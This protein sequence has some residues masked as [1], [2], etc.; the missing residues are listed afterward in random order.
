MADT[1][2]VEINLFGTADFSKLTSE[3]TALKAQISAVQKAASSVSNVSI[4]MQGVA[5]AEKNFLA[6][7][8]SIKGM[9]TEMV[10]LADGA[11]H[12]NDRLLKNNRTFG[13]MF[14]TWRTGSKKMSE[15]MRMIGQY[16]AKL[17]ESMVIP[18][19]ALN[20]QAMVL[21]NLAGMASKTK[22]AQQELKA[23]NTEMRNLGNTIVNTGKNMQWAGR[24]L[25]VGITV[26]MVAGGAA[27]ASMFL[28]VD[29]A[30]RKLMM[31]YGVGGQ[32]GKGFSNIVPSPQELEQ[33]RSGVQ[34]VA[35]EM[36]GLYGQSA[37]VTTNIAADLA[38]AGYTQQ[39]LLDLTKVATNA[40]VLGQ[41]DQQSAVKATISIQNAYRLSMGQTTEAL[42]FFSAAQAA[43]STTMN[44][45]IDA[46]PRVGPI[47]KNLGGTYK[48]TVALLTAMKEGGV[49]AGEGANALKNSMQRIVAPTE[50]AKKTL[51]GFGVNLDQIAKSGSPVIMIEKLQ[52]SLSKLDKI[53]RQQAITELFGK[54]QAARMTALLDNFNRSGTQ[55]AKVMQMMSLSGEELRKIQDRQIK[56]LQ[57]SP[58]MRFQAAIQSLKTSLI[59][60][61]Q[62]LIELATPLIN[63]LS[64]IVDALK[65]IG[66]IKYLLAGGLGISAIVGPMIMLGGLFSNLIGQMFKM[67][68]TFRMFRQGFSEG[69]GLSKPFTAIKEGIKGTQNYLEDFDASV[70]ASKEA[71]DQ[72]TVSAE[73]QKI[74]FADLAKA[75]ADYRKELEATMRIN[76]GGGGGG[77]P[78]PGGM[79]FVPTGGP[80]NPS[81]LIGAA[82]MPQKVESVNIQLAGG[83][84]GF[85]VGGEKITE[86]SHMRPQEQTIMGSNVLNIPGYS[87]AANA[88]GGMAVVPGYMATTA[89]GKQIN[90]LS[91]QT[92]LPIVPPSMNTEANA[93][94]ILE[95]LGLKDV[96][97]AVVGQFMSEFSLESIGSTEVGKMAQLEALK[98]IQQMPGAYQEFLALG[99]KAGAEAGT[100][101][102]E[103]QRF[104]ADKLG[105]EWEQI[106]QQSANRILSLYE[107]AQQEVQAAIESQRIAMPASLKEQLSITSSRF[108]ELLSEQY[109]S[110]TNSMGEQFAL[111]LRA[112]STKSSAINDAMKRNKLPGLINAGA[113][114]SEMAATLVGSVQELI[115]KVTGI[116][117][118]TT[119]A[120]Q[121]ASSTI[122]AVEPAANVG[123]KL[124]RVR[125]TAMGIKQTPI[126][127]AGGGRV[128]G[129]GGPK[130][131]K[132]PAML[133]SGEYVVNAGAVSHYGSGLMDSINA[134]RFY[135]GGPANAITQRGHIGT[136]ETGFI[137]DMPD[138]MNQAMKS[139]GRGVLVS[140]L[141]EFWSTDEAYATL[142]RAGKKLGM[143]DSE[144]V[145]EL[146]RLKRQILSELDKYP[147]AMLG[148]KM[149][150][151]F[152]STIGDAALEKA[153]GGKRLSVYNNLFDIRTLRTS[154]S[155]K[156]ELAE[157]LSRPKKYLLERVKT[158]KG[159]SVGYSM[160]EYL[161]SLGLATDTTTAVGS[162]KRAIMIEEIMSIIRN[163]LAG[164]GSISG[165]GGPKDDMIPAMLSNGEYVVNADAVNHYGKGFMDSVNAKRFAGGGIARLSG[166]SGSRLSNWM[167]GDR[168]EGKGSR[169][170]AGFK[171]GMGSMMGGTALSMVG[172]EI[173]GAMEQGAGGATAMSQGMQYAGT[174]AMLGSMFGPW[175]MLIGAAGGGILGAYLGHQAEEERRVA[176]EIQH[177]IDVSNQYRSTLSISTDELAQMGLQMKSIT[178]VKFSGVVASADEMQQSIDALAESMKNGSQQSKDLISYLQGGSEEERSQ[179]LKRQ[180]YSVL[181]AGGTKDL[182]TARVMAAAKAAGTSTF[183]AESISKQLL[184]ELGI[185]KYGEKGGRGSLAYYGFKEQFKTASSGDLRALYESAG[186]A[187]TQRPRPTARYTSVSG[188]RPVWKN[189]SLGEK[190]PQEVADKYNLRSLGPDFNINKFKGSI[191]DIVSSGAGLTGQQIFASGNQ[192]LINAARMSGITN[193]TSIEDTKN[194]LEQLSGA[195]ENL[196]E[197]AQNSIQAFVNANN[198]FK[199]GFVKPLESALK[200][201]SGKELTDTIGT[202]LTSAGGNLKDLVDQI[203]ADFSPEM[204]KVAQ[205]FDNSKAAATRFLMGL[206]SISGLSFET[207]QAQ[208]AAAA[209]VAAPGSKLGAAA[210]AQAIFERTVSETQQQLISGVPQA[211]TA[212][213]IKASEQNAMKAESKS[214]QQQQ[215]AEQ[216]AFKQLQKNE[217][218]KIKGIQKEI[219][220][221]QKLF[222]EKQRQ[223]EQDQTL[224]GLQNQISKARDEGDLLA[225]AAA[226]SAY[227]NELDKQNAEEQK[228][229][230]DE[231][232]Q[233]RIDN[234]Q[235]RMDREQEAFDKR[236]QAMQDA[237]Q[238]SQEAHQNN[239]DNA[240][241]EAVQQKKV[242]QEHQADISLQMK[243]ISDLASSKKMGEEEFRQLASN[244]VAKLAKDTSQSTK[245]VFDEL[246]GVYLRGQAYF[247]KG[248]KFGANGSVTSLK[249]PNVVFYIDPATGNLMAKPGTGEQWKDAVAAGAGAGANVVSNTLPSGRTISTTNANAGLRFATGGYISGPGTD[250]S[251]SIPARLSDGE[252]VVKA[253]SV[254]QYGTGFMDAVNAG[255][256]AKG[257]PVTG[258]GARSINGWPWGESIPLGTA[259]VPGTGRSITTRASVLPLFVALARDYAQ[260]IRKLTKDT[261]AFEARPTEFGALS[262]HGS[263]TAID[264]NSGDEGNRALWEMENNGKQGEKNLYNWW[265][266]GA[267]AGRASWAHGPNS[268]SQVARAL[269]NKYQIF[270]WGGSRSLG[271]DYGLQ[272]RPANP[273]GADVKYDDYMHWALKPGTT[274]DDVNRV[275]RQL[276]I[277]G[278]GTGSIELGP[279]GAF[280]ITTSGTGNQYRQP[281]LKDIDAAG[282]KLLFSGL[283]FGLGAAKDT[284]T[285]WMSSISG[286]AF[287]KIKSTL[288]FGGMS[289]PEISGGS[290]SANRRLAQAMAAQYGWTGDQWKALDFIWQHESGF[291]TTSYDSAQGS[292][293]DPVDP[294]ARLTWGIPQANPAHKMASAGKDW[295]TNPAT[296]IAWGLRYIKSTYGNPMNA[297]DRGMARGRKG[298]NDGWGWYADG[299][300]ILGPGGPKDDLIPALLSNGE[301]IIRASSVNRYGAEM[302]ESINNGTFNPAFSKP[303][304]RGGYISPRDTSSNSVSNNNIEYNINVNVAGTNASPDEIASAVMR[305]LKQKQ[306]A[307][308]ANRIIG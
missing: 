151:S 127:A 66:P 277:S 292:K 125:Q 40:M 272:N 35:Q 117:S 201:L 177:T 267:R 83:R 195:I 230:A 303:L 180:F 119:S 268:P 295:V 28:K 78:G 202:A 116:M 95:T 185:G 162:G 142:A 235:A 266:V 171:P 62:K 90:T 251:D 1:N 105:P 138:W 217:Q 34:Q 271:G 41:T 290:N 157:N 172:S 146:R 153:F 169:F 79:P 250:T 270:I 71:A 245:Q 5:Q 59:P 240:D 236:M 114:A 196:N 263:G 70:Y 288:P 17:H 11:A 44:D 229:K 298:V 213:Q 182:A 306:K 15:D 61:G 262:D 33:V 139:D 221:R 233:S 98:R 198:S 291:S 281:T 82:T 128:Y 55:S 255:R 276:G 91:G 242:S 219:D 273:S 118:S 187:L 27:L 302:M 69:G 256:F 189:S 63:G 173:G 8:S 64:W 260:N 163:M 126:R 86:F 232:D 100:T 42:Q 227:N 89:L 192:D 97:K 131:D 32:A 73:E 181:E 36:A 152:E 294:R 104:F 2:R 103:I 102:A 305:T 92:G 234:I 238:A 167:F 4:N 188:G 50:S 194:K 161:R 176:S 47:I 206:K 168:G 211:K 307:N 228:R 178:D 120:V 253:S 184:A 149:H 134:K 223:I 246:K 9:R 136:G 29:E 257:G 22:A 147:G 39:Q 280:G 108:S 84:G 107:Q 38:A 286:K 243:S 279:M 26:P 81:G 278:T 215:R 191:G 275:M 31:V 20:G 87:A 258:G 52:M 259:E 6:A 19:A 296:Q 254:R 37:E 101:T 143:T 289:I 155:I 274:Q 10:N 158:R 170:K 231:K 200:T 13:E 197:S 247:D 74:A 140:D 210:E 21:T 12:L 67:G 43:T 248:Y 222:D 175:G 144:I 204:E 130:D 190:L 265:S 285:N 124:G 284:A 300:K 308:T 165:S 183:Q 293:R 54:F 241:K 58:S 14:S 148:G 179:A 110:I 249:Y 56:T 18:S 99:G 129:P 218:A 282:M 239:I 226:Q 45:L 88:M 133:S 212:E 57:E 220:M 113:A 30:M 237:F 132:I 159:K 23:Y 252:Y 123:A 72:L 122:I 51:Q 96:S 60:V 24:Q 145:I 216:E 214:F 156:E 150:P 112:E 209:A 3:L 160:P 154:K 16:Q 193:E 208:A 166:G 49:A 46:V 301:Y 207:P 164:G 80:R 264:I 76:P 299:G 261:Y 7:T 174:G 269:K 106:Q 94:A 283:N 65:N 53:S 203:G 141:V 304:A 25:T 199:E 77:L 186:T 111:Q 137:A 225:L 75:I 85:M 244:N 68:Q 93:R 121:Q 48:D 109:L 224:L 205:E 135:Q 115:Q 297:Y 287:G